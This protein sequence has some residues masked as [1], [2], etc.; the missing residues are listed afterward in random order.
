MKN[1]PETKQDIKKQTK[2]NQEI[3]KMAAI[4][5]GGTW[6]IVSVCSNILAKP[7]Q[8]FYCYSYNTYLSA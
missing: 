6:S 4:C 3:I 5:N 1:I 2:Q 7:G 8:A